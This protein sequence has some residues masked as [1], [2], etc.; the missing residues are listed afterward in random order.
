MAH[1]L[2]EMNFVWVFL[3]IWFFGHFWIF[4]ICFWF[5]L[6][7]HRFICSMYKRFGLQISSPLLELVWTGASTIV[8]IC[9]KSQIR[10]FFS[11]TS[12]KKCLNFIISPCKALARGIYNPKLDTFWF[13]V[14]TFLIC[15]YLFINEMT[16]ISQKVLKLSLKSRSSSLSMAVERS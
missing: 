2:S 5:W 16:N 3:K 8:C 13:N 7:R 12:K 1:I 9:G 4:F 14:V 15:T 6:V 11:Q 10:I